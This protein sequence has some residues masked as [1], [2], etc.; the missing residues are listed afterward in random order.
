LTWTHSALLG[1]SSSPPA[2]T[3]DEKKI[4]FKDG[5]GPIK[6]IQKIRRRAAMYIQ[7]FWINDFSGTGCTTSP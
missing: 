6:D 2:K 4:E 7:Y 1:C 5:K 3:E